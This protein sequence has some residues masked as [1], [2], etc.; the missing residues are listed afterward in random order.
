MNTTLRGALIAVAAFASLPAAVKAADPL[1]YSGVSIAQVCSNVATNNNFYPARY[2]MPPGR[3]VGP[4]TNVLVTQDSTNEKW[5]ILK[6]SH[7]RPTYYGSTSNLYIN[8]PAVRVW[9]NPTNSSK[10]A[11]SLNLDGV[12]SYCAMGLRGKG[13]DV[14]RGYPL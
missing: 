4:D 13:L 14:Q 10:D 6:I 5:A 7:W 1:P 9:K 12:Y 8:P 11:I 2:L 3:W